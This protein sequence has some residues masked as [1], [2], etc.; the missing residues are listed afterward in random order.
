[1]PIEVTTKHD[2]TLNVRQIFKEILEDEYGVSSD[3]WDGDRTLTVGYTERN[4]E[5]PHYATLYKTLGDGSKQEETKLAATISRADGE[6]NVTV[7]HIE[8]TEG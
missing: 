1:M 5:Y 4:V 3:Q 6:G 7:R 2:S 8:T